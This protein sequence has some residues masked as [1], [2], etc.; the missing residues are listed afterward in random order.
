MHPDNLFKS[1]KDG[2]YL[3]GYLHTLEFILYFK[4]GKV[5][6]IESVI[7]AK[8]YNVNKDL[9][10][11]FIHSSLYNISSGNCIIPDQPEPINPIYKLV[12]ASSA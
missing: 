6:D 1:I 3:F 11:I 8:T 12:K 7:D 2:K 10:N 5:E 9:K 4:D